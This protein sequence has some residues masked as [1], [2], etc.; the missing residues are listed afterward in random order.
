MQ[1][2]KQLSQQYDELKDLEIGHAHFA[3]RMA[4]KEIERLIENGLTQEEFE[5]TRDFLISYT[6]LYA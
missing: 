1:I 6:R 5:T 4:L 3:L 2:A